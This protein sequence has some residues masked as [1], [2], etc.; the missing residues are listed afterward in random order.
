MDMS[1][2]R[3]IKIFNSKKSNSKEALV[4]CG[5]GGAIWQTKRLIKRLNQA[6]YNVTA[7]DFSSEV[8][9]KG[10]PSLLVNLA[11]E[12]VQ[13]AEEQ[14]RQTDK[15][16][17]LV[18]I[19]LGALMS[20]NIL[21]RSDLF[22]EAIMITGG[23]IVKVAQNIYGKKV[24]PQTYEDLA[25]E[26]QNVNMYTEPERLRGKRIIFLLPA[27]DRLIDTSDVINEIS[28]QNAAGNNLMLITRKPF[29]HLGTIV[30]ETIFSPGRIIRY[31]KLIS[32]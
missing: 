8:L 27:R 14:A 28:I 26:W 2:I 29:G 24:W 32:L 16:I 20:L 7:L 19:S 10:D 25:A 13:F 5:F 18:G 21:R 31:V 6:G 12:V 23:D 11:D 9:S 3:N 22:N 30:Q 1:L 4:L 15:K 17:L